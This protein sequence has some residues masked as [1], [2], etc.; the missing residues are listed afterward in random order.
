M[1]LEIEG[2]ERDFGG[3]IPPKCQPEVQS[4]WL[5]TYLRVRVWGGTIPPHLRPSGDGVLR[6]EVVKDE[7]GS[8][9]MECY[10]LREATLLKSSFAIS[11]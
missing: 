8:L 11:F 5:A 7:E 6:N 2:R 1:R 4:L 3:S 9:L 10:L